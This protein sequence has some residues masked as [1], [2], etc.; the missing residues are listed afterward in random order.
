MKIQWEL[1]PWIDGDIALVSQDDSENEGNVIAVF[2]GPDKERN[3]KF[4]MDLLAKERK[5]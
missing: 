1:E 2:G 4:V 3:A 5:S